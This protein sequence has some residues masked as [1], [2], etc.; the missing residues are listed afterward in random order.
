[1]GALFLILLHLEV[2]DLALK[3]NPSYPEVQLRD[4]HFNEVLLTLIITR[5]RSGV[6]LARHLR[7]KA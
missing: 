5:A 7:G 6:N 3:S 1:M 2:Y 4:Y